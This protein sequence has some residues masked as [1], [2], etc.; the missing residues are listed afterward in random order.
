MPRA[1][2]GFK[3]RARVKKVLK[4]AKGYHGGRSKLVRTAM[5]TVDKAL[6]YAYAG[7][8]IKKRDFRALWQTRI[9]A[10]SKEN[11]LSYSK[12]IGLLKKKGCELD[13]KSLSELAVNHPK[14]FAELVKWSNS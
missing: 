1:K 14:D 2:R 4:K 11:G 8:K 3:R 5:E 12:F 9:G 10:A 13:R 6:K 7:R